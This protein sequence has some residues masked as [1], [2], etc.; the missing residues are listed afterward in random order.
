MIGSGT[1]LSPGENIECKTGVKFPKAGETVE[2][3]V[4]A[5]DFDHRTS[6]NCQ[7]GSSSARS[8]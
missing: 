8:C 1:V 7:V 3:Q 4:Q 5:N 6:Y 2:I